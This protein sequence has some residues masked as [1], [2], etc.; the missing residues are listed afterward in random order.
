M[1][2]EQ[3]R[4]EIQR[5]KRFNYICFGIVIAGILAACLGVIIHQNRPVSGSV[6]ISGLTRALRMKEITVAEAGQKAVVEPAEQLAEL[7]S[8]EQWAETERFSQKASIELY[9]SEGYVLSLYEGDLASAFDEYAE[10]GTK[11]TAYYQMPQGA[12]EQVKAYLNFI[13]NS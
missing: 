2:D 10:S 9:F 7:L 4:R 8:L 13:P 11:N 12:L 5:A 6:S 1:E 3:A